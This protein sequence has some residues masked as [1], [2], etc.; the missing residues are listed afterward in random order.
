M[1]K[2]KTHR[3]AAKRFKRTGTGKIARAHANKQHILTKKTSRRKRRLRKSALVHPSDA[4]RI[5]HMVPTL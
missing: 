1:P 5:Q 3:G 2:M 4:G